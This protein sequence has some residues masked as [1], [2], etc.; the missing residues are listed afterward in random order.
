GSGESNR[1]ALL[2]PISFTGLS[3]NILFTSR[4]RS[5][6]M[7][8]STPC[9]YLADVRNSTPSALAFVQLAIMVGMSQ[10]APHWYDVRPNFIF[11]TRAARARE[12][13]AS[14]PANRLRRVRVGCI[15]L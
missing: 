1:S 2:M 5:G 11:E 12:A 13:R 4:R 6:V 10:S 9:L 8:G 14:D 3:A 15:S 7:S